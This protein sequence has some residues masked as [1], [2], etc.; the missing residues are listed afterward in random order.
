MSLL[1]KLFGKSSPKQQEYKRPS[2]AGTLSILVIYK[3]EKYDDAG[4][5]IEE[6]FE[7]IEELWNYSSIDTSGYTSLDRVKNDFG[8]KLPVFPEYPLIG[9]YK[10]ENQLF[11]SSDLKEVQQFIEEYERTYE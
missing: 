11:I 6:H 2:Y 4:E 5:H 8:T 1:S 10:G 7:L 9:V 3:E